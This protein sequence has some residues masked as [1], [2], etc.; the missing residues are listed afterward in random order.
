MINS[1]LGRTARVA[2]IAVLSLPAAARSDAALSSALEAMR[3][4]LATMAQ[5]K[6]QS[7]I[8]AQV[9]VK[10]PTAPAGAWKKI[11]DK[12]RH[13]GV[14]GGDKEFFTQSL[15]GV[16]GNPKANHGITVFLNGRLAVVGVELSIEQSTLKSGTIRTEFWEILATASGTAA[17]AIYKERVDVPGDEPTM[18]VPVVVNLADPRAKARFD[19]MIDYWSAR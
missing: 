1:P 11:I 4:P 15:T 17:Q 3:A 10:V 12:L 2:A 16:G 8:P 6:T 13:D 18:S 7:R 9:Q 14:K 19:E 5:L